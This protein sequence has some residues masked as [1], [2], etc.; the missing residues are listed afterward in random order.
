MKR[1]LERLSLLAG[2][3]LL[4]ALC[5]LTVAGPALAGS[6]FD[7][8]PPGSQW[9]GHEVNAKAYVTYA[10]FIDPAPYGEYLR[11]RIIADDARVTGTQEA[12]VTEF[13][14]TAGGNILV[15]G[16][17]LLTPDIGGG[18]WAGRVTAVV[19]SGI[20]AGKPYQHLIREITYR[21]SGDFA[22]LVFRVSA[23]VAGGK[24]PDIHM[25]WISKGWIEPAE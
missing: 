25:P 7:G 21:G 16:R 15:S 19:S 3:A 4:V 8:T 12:W 20:L 14:P 1:S 23:H 6:P 18:D 11:F 9:G 2:L 22:G 17:M 10:E 13:A 5:L 24:A